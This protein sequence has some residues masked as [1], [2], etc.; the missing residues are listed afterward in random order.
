MKK[1]FLL[2][3]LI[4]TSVFLSSCATTY[5][6]RVVLWGVPDNK[7]YED[8]STRPVENALPAFHFE[9]SSNGETR[10]TELFLRGTV[11]YTFEEESHAKGFETLLEETG[12]TGFI[13]IQNDEILYEKYF[14][15]YQR[16]SINTSASVAKAFVGAL[17]G[18]AHEEG[19]IGSLDDPITH[20]IPEMD[21]LGFSKITIRQ[22]LTMSSGLKH[23]WFP[24]LWGDAARA[25]YSPDVRKVAMDSKILEVPD[26]HYN[27]NNNHAQLLG[28]I[29][30]RVIGRTVSKYLEE[31]IWK[32]LGM[33]FPASWSLDGEEHGFELM[34]Y[35]L[36]ARTI[37]FA[38]FGRL[39]LNE[40]VWQENRIL[41][42]DFI[43]RSTLPVAKLETVEGYYDL[44]TTAAI[45]AFFHEKDGYYSHHWFGYK[46]P[47]DWHDFF[48]SGI[49]GQFIYVSPR[50]KLIIVRT[51]EKQGDIDWWPSLFRQMATTLQIAIERPVALKR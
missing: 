29:L 25:L 51:S 21:G 39:Y 15:G 12:T 26:L 7:D 1:K 5:L 14:N 34:M 8:F 44:E 49:L 48:V 50:N 20:Y 35:G 38:K 42:K 2:L 19:Y 31:K 40:G 9:N 47:G 6:G 32:P 27:Y 45:T 41:S 33:E 17:V 22:L 3:V 13:V 24:L 37:D 43:I 11:S 16:D 46:N 28:I 10:F 23:T 18:I 36:N 4:C 30:E